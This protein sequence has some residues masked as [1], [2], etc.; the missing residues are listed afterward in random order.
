[1]TSVLQG[2]R[3]LE[4][5]QWT[6]APAAAGV[7]ADFGADVIKVEDPV[8]G[9]PQRGL[10]TAGIS[11][12]VD[13]VNLVHEQTNR[14]KRSIGLD[15]RTEQGH[16]VLA[17]L[18]ERCDVFLT[19]FLAPAR[20]KLGIEV[21][22]I[23]R[24]NPRIVYA[25][26]TGQGAQGPDADLGGYDFTAYWMRSGI[27][28]SLAP[29]GGETLVMQPPAFGDKAAAMNLAFGIA[30]ALF[31]R[32]RTGQAAVVDVSLLGTALWQNSSAVTYTVGLR[33]EFPIQTRPVT[34]PLAH[35]YRTADG[36]WLVL[37]MLESDRYW[38][39]L[40]RHIG[41][42]DL[43]SDSRFVDAGARREH[44]DACVQELGRVFA[45]ADLATWRERLRTVAGPWAPAQT[46]LEASQDL[47]TRANGC[48]AEL[49]DGAGGT[50]ATVVASP[51]RFDEASTVLGRAPEHGEHTESVLL[52]LG[53]SWDDI[54]ALKDAR[55]I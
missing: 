48:L 43:M 6:F 39:D 29:P 7:L 5:A 19:N 2:V 50:R 40:C 55:I 27:A 47:Q 46:M 13:G 1:M 8:T 24:I 45:G 42:E 53:Y 26:A 11:P 3:V 17:R 22:D 52:D 54:T 51:V 20:V 14:G 21:D 16:A 12:V 31:Q 30:A 10:A 34:N 18:V 44:S 15:L 32:E 49:D 36:R 38:S 23:R 4:V 41:R 28:A 25:R 9:D 35:P 37:M 33:R